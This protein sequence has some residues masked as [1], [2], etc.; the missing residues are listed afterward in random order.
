MG[1]AETAAAHHPNMLQRRKTSLIP[2]WCPQDQDVHE[3]PTWFTLTPETFD[4]W[5]EKRANA[6]ESTTQGSPDS[7]KKTS[8]IGCFMKGVGRSVADHSK[9][10]EAKQWQ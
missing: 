1:T 4:A 7:A 3:P 6:F 2:L 8:A 10:K 5:R 9:F